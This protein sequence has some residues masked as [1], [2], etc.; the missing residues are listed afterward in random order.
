LILVYVFVFAIVVLLVVTRV[1][2]RRDMARKA[3]LARRERS[4]AEAGPRDQA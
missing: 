3:E 4:E 2:G 1:A